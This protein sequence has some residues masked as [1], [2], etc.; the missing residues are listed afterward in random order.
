[1]IPPGIPDWLTRRRTVDA[2]RI[3]LTGRAWCGTAPVARVEV[4]VDGAWKDA[5]LDDPLGQFAWRGW[6]YEWE[7]TP[8][9]HILSCRATDANGDIQPLEQPWNVQGMGNN[10]VQAVPVV[11]R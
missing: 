5:S 4:G 2:G 9:E 11:V 7:A 10:L 1:M 3:T 6:Q 8:G